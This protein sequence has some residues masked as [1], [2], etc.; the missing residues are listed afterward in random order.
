MPLVPSF[1][2]AM[3]FDFQICVRRSVSFTAPN[4]SN[5]LSEM[6]NWMTRLIFFIAIPVTIL[7]IKRNELPRKN[8]WNEKLLV[9]SNIGC[10]FSQAKIA[11]RPF[12][13][14]IAVA[15]TVGTAVV[16]GQRHLFSFEAEHRVA[17]GRWILECDIIVASTFPFI[18]LR[19]LKAKISE[20]EMQLTDEHTQ[21]WKTNHKTGHSIGDG[22]T[23]EYVA[24]ARA[25]AGMRAQRPTLAALVFRRF[26][27]GARATV[28]FAAQINL[29]VDVA[30]HESRDRCVIWSCHHSEMICEKK[31]AAADNL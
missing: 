23:I 12:A 29:V 21:N 30:L 2:N 4:A 18:S 11:I 20:H 25:E 9:S 17:V 1:K 5:S 22:V 24:G 8:R 15:E 10:H 3:L 7:K 28:L 16:C 13:R 6:L 31:K 26:I 27:I 19:K 14:L